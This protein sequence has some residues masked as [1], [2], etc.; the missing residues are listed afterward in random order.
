M[1]RSFV[2]PFVF[3]SVYFSLFVISTLASD[4]AVLNRLGE[5]KFLIA[6]ENSLEDGYVTEKFWQ[7]F[8]AGTVPVYIGDDSGRRVF[9][10]FL[11]T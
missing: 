10:V 1:F 2:S 4:A 5:Y 9:H 7:G 6:V 3:S 8:A 11:I